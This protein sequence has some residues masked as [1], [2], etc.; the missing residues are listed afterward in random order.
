[1]L[2]SINRRTSLLLGGAGV[3]M[4]A[5][6]ALPDEAQAQAFN[7]TP[8][9][10][11]GAV[12]IDRTIS[13][14]DT[15]TVSSSTAVVDWTP[16]EDQV[17]NALTFLP[18]GATAYF[19]DSPGQ[20]GFAILNR[21]LPTTGGDVTVFAGTVISRL[22]DADG[23]LTAGGMVAFYSP[24]G[25][26]VGGTAVFDVG[27]LMLTT[28]DPDLDSFDSFAAGETLQLIG[29]PGATEG[30][31]VEANALIDA[32][33][34]GSYFVAAAP[35]ISMQGEAYVN[36]S[37]AYIAGEQVNLTY[38]NGLF[39]I[40]IPAGTGVE[41][42]IEHTG[43]T[44]G[45]ASVG[46]GDNHVI[47][48]VGKAAASNP[49]SLLLSGNLGF[50]PAVS[51]T[52]DNGDIIL[53][54]GYDVFGR[55]VTT[56]A[57][58]ADAVEESISVAG[59]SD[60]SA[61]V[62]A[63]AT[64]Q[65]T[66]NSG[67]G[68]VSF[69]DGLTVEAAR[70]ISLIA[71]N[72][73]NLSIDGATN[74]LARGTFAASGEATGGTI[75][76]TAREG[77][78]FTFDG[79]LTANATPFQS[80]GAANGGRIDVTAD[81]ATM[82]LVGDVV[83]RAQANDNLAAA[84]GDN[85][86]GAATLLAQNS[87]Q[88]QIAG[89]LLVDTSASAAGLGG[90]DA[91]GGQSTVAA[92][93]GGLVD[94]SGDV[95]LSANGVGGDADGALGI[96][97]GGVGNG[98]TANV[99]ADDGT[100]LFGG[101]LALD[102]QG[103]GGRG[104]SAFGG[105]P[106][107]T[108]GSGGGG[109]A[110]LNALQGGSISVV[111]LTSLSASGTGGE[112]GSGG[113]GVAGLAQVFATDTAAIS[114]ADVTG[115]ARGTGAN[116]L[117]ANGI[118][119]SGEGG[120]VFIL[121][122]G[123][124]DISVTGSATLDAIA[125]GGDGQSGGDATGGEAGVYAMFGTIAVD[126]SVQLSADAI[127]GD[128]TVGF[129]GN[130]GN[131]L[132]GTAYVQA[133][134]SEE[135]G[136]RLTIAGDATMLASG[137][138]GV[139]G[140][141][142]GGAIAAGSGGSGTGG[143]YQGTPGSGGAFAIA[144][145]DT[146]ELSIGG[147]TILV[148]NGFGGAGGTGGTG[149]AGGTG[150]A[151]TGGTAQAGTFAGQGSGALGD[152]QAIYD[153]L[154]LEA[155]GTGGA[156]GA[157][158]SGLGLGG[159]GT[160][161][162][163]A[164]F[165]NGSLVSAGDI[166]TL[167]DGLGGN[168]STGGNGTGGAS[169]FGVV[170]GTLIADT[171]ASSAHGDG[172]TGST[173]NGGD[174]TGGEASLNVDGS[175]TVA[176]VNFASNGRGGGSSTGNGGVGRGGLAAIGVVA[177]AEFNATGDV[178][179]TSYADGGAGEIGGDAFAGTASVEVG[180]DA[181]ASLAAVFLAASAEGG[182]GNQLGGE[183]LGGSAQIVLSGGNLTASGPVNILASGSGGRGQSGGSGGDGYGG[184]AGVIVSRGDA[185]FDQSLAIVADG[186]GGD[187]NG[188]GG[189][190]GD[191]YGGA[192]V[193]LV[194]GDALRAASMSVQGTLDMFVSGA[195]GDGGAGDGDQNA[196][197]AGGTGR[198]GRND[199]ASLVDS[200]QGTGSY[201]N[202][203]ADYGQLLVAGAT[204]VYSIGLGGSGGDAPIG[205]VGGPGGAAF[206][207]DVFVGVFDPVDGGPRLGSAA[208]GDLAAFSFA[209]GGTGGVDG[210]EIL[211]GIG[212][213][214]QGGAILVASRGGLLTADNITLTDY[215]QGG[216]GAIGGDGF[217]GQAGMVTSDGGM[218]E[219]GDYSATAF[220]YGG[221]GQTAGGDGLGGTAFI[222][223]QGGSTTVSGTADVDASGFGGQSIDGDGGDG[224]GGSADIAIFDAIAGTGSFAGT[225]TVTA[226]GFGGLVLGSGAAGSGTGGLAYVRSQAGGQIDFATVR[227]SASG[228]G[229]LS[230]AGTPGGD[231]IGGL[232]RALSDS[233]G[234]LTASFLDMNADGATT[235]GA[236]D[237][238][239][240]GGSMTLTQLF[241]GA[242][243]AAA[244]DSS[245]ISAVGGSIPI[246]G[247]ADIVLTGDLDIE[248]GQGGLIGG[249]DIVAPTA[250][251]YIDT[252]GGV[253]ITGDNDTTIS[254][255]GSSLFIRSRQLDILAG[256]RIG[257]DSLG[258]DVVGNGATTVLGGTTE[259]AGY[260]LTQAEL[261]RIDAGTAYFSSSFDGSASDDI[262]IRDM[263][264]SG[265]LDDGTAAVFIQAGGIARVEGTLGYVDAAPSDELSI[266]ASRLEIVTPGGI[267]ILDQQGN[268][269]GIFRF[270]GGDF[271]MAD[272]D[273]IA[274]LR[275]AVDFAGR[276]EVLATAADGSDD[277]LGYLRAGDV[278]LNIGS[279]LLVRNTGTTA[280]P[281]GITVSGQLSVAGFLDEDGSTQFPGQDPIDVFAYGRQVDADGN[282]VV[283]E[284]F[285]GLV[286]YNRVQTDDNIVVSYT[287]GSQ[288]NDCVINTGDCGGDEPPP[289][290]P[291]PTP[292][293]HRRNAVQEHVEK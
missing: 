174:G 236:F 19:Q 101:S 245:R 29:S 56:G 224:T 45:P 3:A 77:S 58:D 34:E 157:G 267:G 98:G 76:I 67:S 283:G 199:F 241:A 17:G 281:G 60:F 190:G 208:F 63:A 170:G 166:T 100:I 181:T 188:P 204:S 119:G 200:G 144:G 189:D 126:G 215:A 7:A 138:G 209:L 20:G 10:V 182:D 105:G 97:D 130:G 271:W 89:T 226:N 42:A 125:S 201:I 155:N 111:G 228:T 293:T 158:A 24:T 238:L 175:A 172:G 6:L 51:A 268:P 59:L 239:A 50:D 186:E 223:L 128:A 176:A 114:L 173:G 102:A 161:G 220:G 160:G 225:A 163:A 99:E 69:I 120:R 235:A 129:G 222:G 31:T 214:A 278:S 193:L 136:A 139:G 54:A 49:I 227:L 274:Q 171:L 246:T 251:I 262:L 79:D 231:A 64:G 72:G 37:T 15:I 94:I 106:G 115:F 132:G 86:G 27:Q 243:G 230:A 140:A 261:E 41:T 65:F 156:G 145:R 121:T 292:P 153:A 194:Q 168:G 109:S 28:L 185:G 14:Q 255:G 93:S 217:G 191:G 205:A 25:I 33:A 275:D 55:D 5:V 9:I 71:E 242:V 82:T 116:G 197:G 52:I 179:L 259:T 252:Q 83:L 127:G 57:V 18:E 95:T 211:T 11:R 103:F 47:Y 85:N 202:V 213:E 36:G 68:A 266:S 288:L 90:F 203:N 198:G 38:N 134:G 276:N 280:E 216:G 196:A 91:F 264:I 61:S 206:G 96:I 187:A 147:E 289:P 35:Q 141:G 284:E 30:I 143:T 81:G 240:E 122:E 123:I 12:D 167:A 113:D 78:N 148:A 1:M 184:I 107:D 169:G 40:E 244:G 207:G 232:T 159:A 84:S 22:Q 218:I 13:G 254:F 253:T 32:S 212:G 39:D 233:G 234:S 162:L 133:D 43:I 219:V 287:D 149:Q 66:A 273:T 258:L 263:T 104:A 164:V 21:V 146:G 248:T 53:S 180:D 247:F 210:E 62:F 110:L 260:T 282:A 183:A 221:L 135:E 26:L 151:G 124:G 165:A 73:T 70:A 250:Q 265:T 4:A 75:T 249:P 290:P 154:I 46:A 44:G 152:G 16:F 277:P 229:G 270:F 74:L 108:G 150:G 257:A 88:V 118:G 112:G 279:S 285:F 87:G 269:T 48:V 2:L 92:Q 137:R 272:T 117:A 131:A 80:G 142:D 23:G 178:D 195:G 286:E 192:A 291:P 177:G 237:I 8:E 256:A